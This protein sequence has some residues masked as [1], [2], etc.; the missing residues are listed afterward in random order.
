VRP[1]SVVGHIVNTVNGDDVE[2]V[3]VGGNILMRDKKMLTMEEEEAIKVSR[4]SAEKL[5]QKL[6]AIKKR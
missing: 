5:W 2:T 6:G 4:K 3:I 1:E